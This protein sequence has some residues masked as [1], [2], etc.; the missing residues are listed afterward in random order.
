MN[1][2]I[3]PPP[4]E[5]RP[6]FDDADKKISAKVA[7][8]QKIV[9]EK[10]GLA[11]SADEIIKVRLLAMEPALLARALVFSI[12]GNPIDLTEDDDP[13]EE[14]ASVLPPT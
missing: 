3:C 1:P 9:R 13:E 8:V 11:L 4:G 2:L 14:A 6:T 10:T 5:R 12:T 7:L